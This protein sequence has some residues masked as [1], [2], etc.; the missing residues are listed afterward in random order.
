MSEA[1][2]QEQAHC[3]IESRGPSAAR[4]SAG[5][6][7]PGNIE[8]AGSEGDTEGNPESTIRGQGGGTEGVSD[9]HFPMKRGHR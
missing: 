6:E 7:L 8:T 5:G 3:V 4:R 2:H 1:Y 9:S